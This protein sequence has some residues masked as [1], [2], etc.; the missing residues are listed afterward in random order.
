MLRIPPRFRALSGISA[1]SL[2]LAIVLVGCNDRGGPTAPSSGD[3]SSTPETVV[4]AESAGGTASPPVPPPSVIRPVLRPPDLVVSSLWVD[5]SVPVT[6]NCGASMPNVGCAGGSRGFTLYAVVS[7]IG[8]S[9]VAANVTTL[10]WGFSYSAIGPWN[11]LFPPQSI[12]PPIP[13]GGSVTIQ[14]PWYMGPCDCV[15]PGVPTPYYFTARVDPANVVNESNETNNQL[16]T[17]TVA[18]DQCP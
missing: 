4:P 18:C 12:L 2:V 14:R 17:P 11:W 3:G 6:S 7:N 15:P 1:V 9:R 8:Y 16:G 10:E 13:A 5:P